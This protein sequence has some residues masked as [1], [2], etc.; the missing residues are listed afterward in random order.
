MLLAGSAGAAPLSASFTVTRLAEASDCPDADALD[1]TVKGILGGAAA[2]ELVVRADV[3]FARDALGYRAVMHLRGAKQ[4]ERTLT[5][6][7]P[8]CVALGRAV[9]ITMALLLDTP[10]DRAA[11]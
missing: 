2:R 7:G 10:D 3:E 8:T 6:S 4:G 5:D 9:G 11:A 1:A